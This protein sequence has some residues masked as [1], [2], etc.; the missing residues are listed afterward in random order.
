[1]PI[2]RRQTV[3]E[4]RGELTTRPQG[5]G[6]VHAIHTSGSTGEPVLIEQTDAAQ[7]FARALIVRDHLW[8]GRD[9]SR[10]AAAIRAKL[11]RGAR[12]GWWSGMVNSAFLTGDIATLSSGADVAEQ[13]D[14]LV[15]E[16]PDYLYTY[17]GNARALAL[18]SRKTGRVPEGLKQVI[19]IA[20]ALPPGLRELV[21][22][23]WGAKVIDHYSCEEFGSLALQC[24]ENE[25]L[26]IQAE[27]VYVE[28]LR[29]DG[30]PCAPG[31]VGRVVCTGLHNF[32]MPL[33]RYELGDYAEVG[34][35]CSCGRGLPVL[36]S[37]AGRARNMAVDPTGRRF[38]PNVNV[39]EW[40]E[41]APLRQWQVVQVAPGDL[42][43]RVV[44]NRDLRGDEE[45]AIRALLEK[46]LGYP[47][48][49]TVRRLDEL[50][51]AA[52]GKYEDFLSLL[53]D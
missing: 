38:W 30:T 28:V 49:V 43:V 33:I 31:E 10:K 22:E 35:P 12:A 40:L 13:L 20:S 18:L 16:R 19:C 53:P 11:E 39:K 26:H 15:A 2:L 24:P 29:Q 42:E 32:A 21:R 46:K 7:H 3:R 52:G 6:A 47:Y 34:P 8:Q 4:R 9:F 17:P 37:I 14:W 25:H 1:M 44:A 41:V 27:H 5:H 45:A 36:R 48:A 50:P 51:R 23:V